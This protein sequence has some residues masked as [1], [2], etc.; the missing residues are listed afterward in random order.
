MWLRPKP[1][2]PISTIMNSDVIAEPDKPVLIRLNSCTVRSWRSEDAGPIARH[3]NNR[4]IWINLRDT[5][6]HPYTVH[7]AMS[8]IRRVQSRE[9]QT[10]F[11]I[12]VS[13]EAVGGIG[14]MLH[15]DVEQVSAEVGYWLAE[16]LWGHGI[17]TEALRAITA[18]ALGRHR[19]T[20]MYA[21]SFEWN[22]ASFRVLEKAGYRLE[23]RMR[24]SA[25][26]DGKVIDQL[27]Y[28]YVV[29]EQTGRAQDRY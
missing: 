23:A 27:L 24:R 26:K 28:A 29:D 2:S 20:R 17:A 18:Y 22:H 4:N 12:D 8:F 16:H 7:D 9:P 5:F 25:I 21:V 19:L 13:G 14:F 3:A 6:P 1:W 10:F 11:A 15:D